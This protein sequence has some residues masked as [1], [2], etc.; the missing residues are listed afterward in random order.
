MSIAGDKQP[1]WEMHTCEKCGPH[2][3]MVRKRVGICLN[4]MAK[5]DGI[6]KY[7]VSALICYKCNL[8]FASKNKYIF[9]CDQCDRKMHPNGDCELAEQ[10][11]AR[12][13][14]QEKRRLAVEAAEKENGGSGSQQQDQDV[15]PATSAINKTGVISTMANSVTTEKLA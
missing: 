3:E 13:R 15:V 6:D 5:K 10:Y 7:D 14:L 4:I 8:G 11:H 12:K 9:Y 1:A 2:V